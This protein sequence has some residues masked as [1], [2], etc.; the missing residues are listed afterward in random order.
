M[1]LWVCFIDKGEEMMSN[2]QTA[3][4]CSISEI[5]NY[6]K[7]AKNPM[8]YHFFGGCSELTNELQTKAYTT[9]VTVLMYERN[10]WRYISVIT[11]VL[12]A[13]D[14]DSTTIIAQTS[15]IFGKE[16]LMKLFKELI[17]NFINE[18]S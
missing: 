14:E 4:N 16:K 15:G 11:I 9:D 13:N 10:L 5:T 8:G 18:D 6:I 2:Y 7:N 12:I 1:Y 17:E 3:L